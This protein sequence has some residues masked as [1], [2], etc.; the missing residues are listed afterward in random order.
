[1]LRTYMQCPSDIEEPEAVTWNRL[2]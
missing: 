2:L 1:M